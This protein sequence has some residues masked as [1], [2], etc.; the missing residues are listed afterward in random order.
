MKKTLL[1][2]V[3]ALSL[4]TLLH[5]ED[6]AGLRA[7]LQAKYGKFDK[8]V[9]DLTMVMEMTMTDGKKTNTAEATMSYKEPKFRMDTKISMGEKGGDMTTT[10]IYDGTDMWL[11]MPMMGTRKLAA[12]DQVKY[13]KDRS[14]KWWNYLTENGTV[15]GDEKVGDR[16]CW[17]IEFAQPDK[18]DK[19]AVQP[20]FTKLWLDKE[21]LVQVK[22]EF[23]ADKGK[24]GVAIY[25]DVRPAIGKLEMPYKTEMYADD[26]LVSTAVIKSIDYNKGI[27][28]D[29][30]NVEQAKSQS[31]GLGGH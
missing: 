28:D 19:E 6:I 15:T 24:K 13:N 20:P 9:K 16:D 12:K 31:K 2:A 26:K 8:L 21:T 4:V 22:A 7:Q 17:V 5:A 23:A 29:L 11:I 1:A 3:A 25:S 18:K 14:W 10:V 27:A 30:F